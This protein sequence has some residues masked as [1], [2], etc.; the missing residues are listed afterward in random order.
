MIHVV[1]GGGRLFYFFSFFFL[2]IVDFRRS[3]KIFIYHRSLA[4]FLKYTIWYM[5]L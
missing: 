2:S 3:E 1:G 5:Y 4:I